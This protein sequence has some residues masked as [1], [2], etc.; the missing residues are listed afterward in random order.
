MI[1][2]KYE[3]AGL[4]IKQLEELNKYLNEKIIDI[5]N[6]FNTKKDLTIII[7][8]FKSKKELDNFIITNDLFKP[9][10]YIVGFLNPD[11]N[12]IFCCNYNDYD[13]TLH[14]GETFLEYKKMIL[15]ECVH[16]LHTHY[17]PDNYEYF[18]NC[19]WEGIACYLTNQY[20]ECSLE[21]V[22]MK[23]LLSNNLSYRVY[24]TIVKKI[25][26]KYGTKKVQGLLKFTEDS[27]EILD[28][29]IKEE[30]RKDI[31]VR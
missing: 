17:M 3:N 23:D 7:K 6:F 13:N 30:R 28:Q 11:I 22:N 4:S 16:I 31:N 14:K 15:H 12:K 8:I 5:A 1:K 27:N 25:V 29:I 24:Y 21:N 18:N 26:E 10:P 20:Q 9:E 19:L 2:F